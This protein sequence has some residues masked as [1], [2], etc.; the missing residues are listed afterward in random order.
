M[1]SYTV[2]SLPEYIEQNKSE[3]LH[4]SI[5]GA[6]T[7]TYPIDIITGVKHKQTINFAAITA[8]F[9]TGGSCAFNAS[10]DTTFTQSTI[11][12]T[13]VKVENQFCPKTLEDKYTAKYLR[14]GVKQDVMP[15]EQFITDKVNET[16]ASQMEQA[17]WQGNTAFTFSTNLKQFDGLVKAIDAA[18]PTYATATADVTT[19]NIIGILQEM[20]TLCPA[21]MLSKDLV[22]IMGKDTFR[23]LVVAL[24]NANLYHVPVNQPIS[25]W[26]IIFPYFNIKVIGVDGLSN[27]TN[28]TSTF[29][30]RIFLTYWDN[31]YFATD[32]QNDSENYEMWYSQDDRVFKLSVEWKAGTGVKFGS[33]VVTYKNS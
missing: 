31:L 18:S 22:Y 26:E 17:I 1:S 23:L 28:T 5:V 14:P 8:P 12:V 33:E 10:G 13:E 15:L 21:N 24:G 9:Q 25:N 19:S 27:I 30:D 7:L 6:Q 4:A 20:Y 2:S 16:I 29:K 3:L 11:S 32:L